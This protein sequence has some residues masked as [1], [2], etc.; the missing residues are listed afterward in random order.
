MVVHVR[1]LNVHDIVGT[2]LVFRKQTDLVQTVKAAIIV[3]VVSDSFG[4][5]SPALL[6]W[7]PR[8]DAEQALGLQPAILSGHLLSSRIWSVVSAHL[9]S[10]LSL[11]SSAAD[12]PQNSMFPQ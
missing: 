1:G 8:E 3:L 11:H 6:V 2:I 5:F 12:F 9:I 10:A 4:F 7:Y